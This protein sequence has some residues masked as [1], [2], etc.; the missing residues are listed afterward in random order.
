MKCVVPY[1]TLHP[2]T[3]MVLS[4]EPF[5]IRY[6]HLPEED[7]YRQLMQQLWREGE[8]VVIVEHDIVPWPGAIE[9]LYGCMG[10]WC[11]FSYRLFGGLG[12]FH[13][14]GCCKISS[15]LMKKLPNLWDEPTKWDVLDQKL[16]FAAREV[17]Q[18]VHHHRPAVVHLNPREYQ[19]EKA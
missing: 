17:G 3:Q 4:V 12:I 7:S 11:A 10:Q 13:G 19:M 16:Y 6:V 1:R 15:P 9:E 14:L 8:T 5:P 2:V 18:E